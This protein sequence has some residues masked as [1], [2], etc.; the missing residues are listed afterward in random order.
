MIISRLLYHLR[1]N[2]SS[3]TVSSFTPEIMY[4]AEVKFRVDKYNE[5][6]NLGYATFIRSPTFTVGG[7]EW[8]LN[9]YPDGRSE[10][11]EGHV[12]VALELTGTENVWAILSLTFAG[13]VDRSAWAGWATA[14]FLNRNNNF[15]FSWPEVRSGVLEQMGLVRDDCLEIQCQI[16]V[17][18]PN[19]LLKPGSLPEVEVP[20]SDTLQNLGRFLVDHVTADVTFKVQQE[21]FLAHR[22][23]LAACSPVF[24]RQLLSGEMRE[25]DMGCVLVHDMQPVVFK[26][27]LHF[28]YTDSLVGIGD[29]V[30][31]GDQIELIRHL[32]VAADRYC[33]DRLK[34][35][36][37]AILCKCVDMESLLTTVALADQCH[38]MKLLAACVEFLKY[39]AQTD[40]VESQWYKV[41]RDNHPDVADE[42]CKGVE[43]VRKLIN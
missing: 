21:T 23:M 15:L 28:V 6:K 24:D 22:I 27:L 37:E 25:K 38:C 41:L 1:H 43:D 16:C 30:V 14:A 31:V 3:L 42:I 9:Y 18:R 29:M 26:A 5:R 32:L 34:S 36:C 10:Q 33:V 39:S 13:E 8:T 4:S 11:T 40:M 17:H 7:Y 2:M 35:I 20:A 19:Q 12:S